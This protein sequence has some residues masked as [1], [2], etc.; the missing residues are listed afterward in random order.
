MHNRAADNSQAEPFHI[1]HNHRPKPSERDKPKRKISA[2]ERPPIPEFTIRTRKM[3][4]EIEL[5]FEP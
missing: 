1:I 5:Q 2:C 4:A 3:T